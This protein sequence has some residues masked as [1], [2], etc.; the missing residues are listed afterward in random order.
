MS[1]EYKTILVRFTNHLTGYQYGQVQERR[2][3]PDPATYWGRRP[4]HC[5][6][7]REFIRPGDEIWKTSTTYGYLHRRCGVPVEDQ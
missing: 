6:G 2:Y 1:K 5:K 7:C 4:M 3:Y